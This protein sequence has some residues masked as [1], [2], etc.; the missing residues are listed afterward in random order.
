M[1]QLI[2]GLFLA[3]G[4]AACSGGVA[5]HAVGD[6]DEGVEALREAG[7]DLS[8]PQPLEFYV[9]FPTQAKAQ[10]VATALASRGFEAQAY[11]EQ[12][13]F[14]LIAGQDVLVTEERLDAIE[15][16]IVTLAD[17]NGGRYDGW[18]TAAD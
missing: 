12:G 3:C 14:V 7:F 5:G 15:A 1:R 2:L 4:L 10:N 11:P 16:D 18:D 17:A 8:K 9:M 6:N 13:A